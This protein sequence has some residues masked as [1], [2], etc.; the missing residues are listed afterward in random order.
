M[1]VEA[2]SGEANEIFLSVP[3][4][5]AMNKGTMNS[6]EVQY[7][8]PKSRIPLLRRSN[9]MRLPMDSARTPTNTMRD[10]LPRSCEEPNLP[11][12]TLPAGRSP[13]CRNPFASGK[14]SL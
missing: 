4:R 8:T 10:C 2:L 6:R 13:I 11:C 1:L 12:S 14:R 7:Q 9:S 5:A 3:Q